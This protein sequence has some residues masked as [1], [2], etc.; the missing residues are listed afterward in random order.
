[1]EL[2]NTQYELLEVQAV[3][4]NFEGYINQEVGKGKMAR[5]LQG[6]VGHPTD[7][8]Y[9][10]MVSRKLLLGFPITTYDITN[11]N[12]VVGTD[13][14]GVR[15]NKVRNKPSRFH[16]EEYVDIPEDFINYKIL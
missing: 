12:F 7:R 5:E 9:K 2:I 14:A 6:M 4:V 10:Y 13:L 3:R 1:M 15:V 8:K 11:A 16:T